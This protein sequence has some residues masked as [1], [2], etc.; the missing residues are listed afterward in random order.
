[1]FRPC[2][3]TSSEH[4]G[5]AGCFRLPVKACRPQPPLCVPES[6]NLRFERFSRWPRTGQ[7]KF[8]LKSGK[9]H[10]GFGRSIHAS[11]TNQVKEVPKKTRRSSG[12]REGFLAGGTG[13]VWRMGVAQARLMPARDRVP[14]PAQILGQ[15]L[16]HL[17]GG[18]VGRRVQVL[19]ELPQQAEA[20][21]SDVYS[22]PPCWRSTPATSLWPLSAATCNGVWP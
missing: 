14:G 9:E 7:G 3:G 10:G 22:W 1:M 5:Q 2:F 8:K 4:L 6:F 16:L 21:A 12:D 15:T 19:V 11:L 18:F 17:G 20:V 13:V